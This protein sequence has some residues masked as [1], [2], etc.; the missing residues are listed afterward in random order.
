MQRTSNAVNEMETAHC[1]CSW[2]ELAGKPLQTCN[3]VNE[4]ETAHCACSCQELAG[5][6]LQRVFSSCSGPLTLV[7]SPQPF[8]AGVLSCRNCSGAITG[9]WIAETRALTSLNCRRRGLFLNVSWPEGNRALVLLKLWTLR[10]SLSWSSSNAQDTS[11]HPSS[12]P[13]NVRHSQNHT[14]ALFC[15]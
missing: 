15:S 1:A 3:A 7:P 8:G 5:K 2:Q 12:S 9:G 4:M 10:R 11:V 14:R 6:P 13:V